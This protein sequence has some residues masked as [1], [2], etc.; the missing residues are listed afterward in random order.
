MDEEAENIGSY[1]KDIARMIVQDPYL[2]KMF[3]SPSI[4]DHE[5]TYIQE[6]PP[7][8]EPL[9]PSALIAPD[10]QDVSLKPLHDKKEHQMIAKD[11]QRK[12]FA[13]TPLDKGYFDPYS[14][15]VEHRKCP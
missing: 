4:R 8:A 1:E 13:L 5:E 3:E 9:A 6:S 10:M 2:V 12:N 15:S 11:E 14:K 7:N